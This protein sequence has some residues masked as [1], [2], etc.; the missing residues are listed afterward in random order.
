MADTVWVEISERGYLR[1]GVR[2]DEGRVVEVPSSALPNIEG[3]DPPRGRQVS[4][5]YAEAVRENRPT[6]GIDPEPSSE[7]SYQPDVD[8]TDAA[9]ELAEIY[10]IDLSE[11]EGTGSDDRVIKSDVEDVLEARAG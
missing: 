11:I 5:E 4:R 8:A 2:Y 9:R 10:E 3:V 6:D 1:G 7:P